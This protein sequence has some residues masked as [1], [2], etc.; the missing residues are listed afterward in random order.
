MSANPNAV[1]STPLGKVMAPEPPLD[2]ELRHKNVALRSGLVHGL[3]VVD[4]QAEEIEQSRKPGHHENDVQG[5]QDVVG[6]G[7]KVRVLSD[8]HEVR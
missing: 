8:S 5:F 3:P 7:A 6:H 4:E 2:A 1:A